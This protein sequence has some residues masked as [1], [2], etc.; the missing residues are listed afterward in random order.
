[1]CNNDLFKTL[2]QNWTYS[3]RT[4]VTEP[5]S[6]CGSCLYTFTGETETR[7][8]RSKGCCTSELPSTSKGIIRRRDNVLFLNT[9]SYNWRTLNRQ[10][11]RDF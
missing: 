6:S 3:L 1:M 5:A 10:K 4:G 8:H 11:I 9:S 2:V 7:G